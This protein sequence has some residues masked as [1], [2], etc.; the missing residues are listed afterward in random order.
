MHSNQCHGTVTPV[1]TWH[2]HRGAAL[3]ALEDHTGDAPRLLLLLLH[4]R[5]PLQQLA[6]CLMVLLLLL[7][8]SQ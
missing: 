8:T 5:D 4:Q 1:Q 2:P 7:C 3:P 6:A